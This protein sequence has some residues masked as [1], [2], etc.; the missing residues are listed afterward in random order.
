MGQSHRAGARVLLKFTKG[1]VE[2]YS[3]T[4]IIQIFGAYAEKQIGS[5]ISEPGRQTSGG[6][7]DMSWE[8]PWERGRRE[9]KPRSLSFIHIY[10]YVYDNLNAEVSRRISRLVGVAFGGG[11]GGLG[12]SA[13]LTCL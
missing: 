6:S 8:S 7:C 12:G 4:R 10:I 11:L 3:T 13:R 2:I 5:N 9:G 1:V